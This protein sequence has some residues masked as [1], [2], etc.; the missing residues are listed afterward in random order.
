[1]LTTL[2]H[3]DLSLTR[4][5]RGTPLPPFPGETH[6]ELRSNLKP[7]TFIKDAL[8]VIEQLGSRALDDVYHQPKPM[9]NTKPPYDPKSFLK[10]CITTSGG[11]NYHFSGKRK[12][13]PRE[14]ALFQSF[15]YDY[16]FFGRPTQAMKQVGNA[17]PPVIAE[18][19]YKTIITTL[20]A[21][22]EGLIGAEDDL[23]D[24][25]GVFA[26]LRLTSPSSSPT[27]QTFL[28]GSADLPDALATTTQSEEYHDIES[29]DEE[30]VFLGSNRR[31]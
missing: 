12:Y 25:D 14:M 15:P 3:V 10:G 22:D 13:T 4:S 19:M 21:F 6:G 30:V 11:D 24:L 27:P 28:D 31:H 18:A 16:Q 23:T 1:M 2:T 17:F 5:S 7:V 29:D 20:E 26:Q 8:R 9:A